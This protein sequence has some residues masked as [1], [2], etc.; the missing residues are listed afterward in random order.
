MVS[1]SGKTQTPTARRAWAEVRDYTSREIDSRTAMS[2]AVNSAIIPEL[3]KTRV[4]LLCSD[5]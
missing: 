2:Q 4:R 1:Q 3:I 5:I